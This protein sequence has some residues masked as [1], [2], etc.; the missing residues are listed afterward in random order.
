M[1]KG[2]LYKIAWLLIIGAALIL[3]SGCDSLFGLEELDESAGGTDSP[4][5]T[6]EE[7]TNDVLFSWEQ[8]DGLSPWTLGG[9]D[10]GAG[11][12][13][14]DGSGRLSFQVDFDALRDVGTPS[15]DLR[16][17]TVD[18]RFYVT[19]GSGYAAMGIA[20]IGSATSYS[21]GN[22]FAGS[23]LVERDTVYYLRTEF[24][25]QGNYQRRLSTSGFG[26]DN[27]RL[28]TGSITES[29]VSDRIVRI[30]M[31]NSHDLATN[32]KVEY[33]EIRG[34][35][36]S[37]GGG[38]DAGGEDDDDGDSGLS[39]ARVRLTN[40]HNEHYNA[41]RL[42]PSGTL[43]E[44]VSWSNISIGETTSWTTIE[45]EDSPGNHYYVDYNNGSGWVSFIFNGI[46]IEPDSDCTV[47][48]SGPLGVSPQPSVTCN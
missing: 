37:E 5:D 28:Y 40:A 39:T 38:D 30:H 18:I 3:L 17:S 7:P 8:G 23:F 12:V 33:V 1:L 21:V 9:N 16:N 41:I 2:K 42:D 46:E 13:E 44:A 25:S 35:S 27:A 48:I 10:Q 6:P 20:N 26:D 43:N 47:E 24:D 15:Y 29:Q 11:S 4:T 31:N 19:S 22:E 36:E 45:F 14:I 32:L 34:G